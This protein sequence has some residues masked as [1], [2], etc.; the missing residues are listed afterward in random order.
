MEMNS[1]S[2][3]AGYLDAGWTK[4]FSSPTES[5]LYARYVAAM[6]VLPCRCSTCYSARLR[7]KTASILALNEFLSYVKKYPPT[8]PADYR[9]LAAKYLDSAVNFGPFR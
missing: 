7:F 5:V 8:N 1:Y 4:A 3:T 6:G 2:G 9:S